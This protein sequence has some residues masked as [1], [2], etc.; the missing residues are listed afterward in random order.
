MIEYNSMFYVLAILIVVP[1]AIIIIAY[2]IMMQ[3]AKKKNDEMYYFKRDFWGRTIATI[4]SSLIFSLSLGYGVNVITKMREYHLEEKY[5]W[6]TVAI[7]I[8]VAAT[9]FFFCFVFTKYMK[10][11]KNKDKY[12]K[13]EK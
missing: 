4:Y 10:V 13:K 3:S 9:F 6:L 7:C 12:F 2:L 1:L 11:L 8:L 5:K